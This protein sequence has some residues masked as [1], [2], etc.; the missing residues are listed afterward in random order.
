[1][2]T[3]VSWLSVSRA[4]KRTLYIGADSQGTSVTNGAVASNG[5]RKVWFSSTTPEI[6]SFS[7]DLG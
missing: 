5:V 1:M 3:M 7:G 2:T 6:F 4:G